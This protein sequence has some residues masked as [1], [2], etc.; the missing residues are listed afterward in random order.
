LISSQ[1]IG[2]AERGRSGP[3]S[4]QTLVKADLGQSRPWSKR[5]LV[6]ADLGQIGIEV[7]KMSIKLTH[8]IAVFLVTKGRIKGND[9]SIKMSKVADIG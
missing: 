7:D 1:E 4:K 6:K 5:T 8:I 2:E 9:D 3:W